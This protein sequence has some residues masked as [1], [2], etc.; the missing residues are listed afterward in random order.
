MRGRGRGRGGWGCGRRAAGMLES[1][2]L[3]LL[4]REP[5]HGYTLMEQLGEFGL[6]GID[7][8]AI[9]RALRDMESRQWVSSTWDEEQSQGPA[10]RVYRITESGDE[11]LAAWA[12][13]LDETRKMIDRLLKAYHRHMEEGS[14]AYH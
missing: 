11:V 2:L 8:S 13:D 5:A 1:A 14:G 12:Q 9:Y 10:R 4:H 6:E 3:L 7:P